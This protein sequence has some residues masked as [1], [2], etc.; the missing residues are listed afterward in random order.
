MSCLPLPP[1]QNLYEMVIMT[2]P[3]SWDM[4]MVCM[5]SYHGKK[6]VIMEEYLMGNHDCECINIWCCVI[7]WVSW[8]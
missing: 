7:T 6:V 4:S 8:D 5:E 1:T 2:L 3:I